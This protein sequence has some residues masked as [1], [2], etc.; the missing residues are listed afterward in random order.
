M[1]L[2]VGLINFLTSLLIAYYVIN[3][4]KGSFEATQ[5]FVNQELE[6]TTKDI[7]KEMIK[8]FYTTK[9]EIK[10]GFEKQDKKI[11]KKIDKALAH[12]LD[13]YFNELE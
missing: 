8:G 9:K 1:S 3:F 10:K 11:D 12:P 4:N 13:E 6:T 7:K 2:T 5:D